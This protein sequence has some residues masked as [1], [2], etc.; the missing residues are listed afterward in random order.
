MISLSS[1]KV[2]PLFQIKA[3]L[4]RCLLARKLQYKIALPSHRHIVKIVEEKVHMLNCPLNGDYVRGAEYIWGGNLGC[5][6]GKTPRQKT[7]HIRGEIL[8]FPTTIL[9]IYKSVTLAGDIMFI[10]GIHF[11]NKISRHVK[12]ITVEHFANAKVSTLKESIRQVKK[13]Y[14]QRGFKITNILMDG[15]FTCIRGNL[16]ELKI[17][18]N[19]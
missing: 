5:L 3:L 18:L 19:I 11:I 2:C 8:P 15:Q 6:K 17:N 14:M 10:N 12:F 7:P 16:A 1:Q 9:E 4:R 13:V